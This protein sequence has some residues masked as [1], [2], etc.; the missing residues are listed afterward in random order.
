[1]TTRRYLSFI[2]QSVQTDGVTFKEIVPDYLY[3]AKKDNGSFLMH[4]V[5]VGL[6][7]SASM[8]IAQSK[9]ATYSVLTANEVPAVE[10]MFLRNARSRFAT[11][12]PFQQ[13]IQ[14]FSQWNKKV[15]VKPDTG[16]QGNHVYKVENH[17][18]LV[19]RMNTIFSLEHNIA[20]SPF[21]EAT[22]EYRIITLFQQPKLFIGKQRTTTWKHNLISGAKPVAID[23]PLLAELTTLAK[24]ASAALQL[25]F[26]SIDVL[27]TSKGLRVIEVNDQ[28]M[29]DEYVKSV[30]SAESEVAQIYREAIL[31]RFSR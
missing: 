26:C 12:D 10:H 17:D 11:N 7:N 29:M 19:K 6:N 16:A 31:Q 18:E 25:D 22:Y 14:W 4:D 23:K 21:Y 1:M 27:H 9:T 8:K 3:V 30:P 24:E 13:G 15:V 20:I 2:Q 5:E 28:V